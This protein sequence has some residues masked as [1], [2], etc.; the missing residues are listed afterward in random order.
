M[1]RHI[2]TGQR[3][4]WEGCKI[5]FFESIQAFFS[6]SPSMQISSMERVDNKQ[7]KTKTFWER[8]T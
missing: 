8:R 7:K 2:F 1:I 5:T 4:V 6:D 3:F